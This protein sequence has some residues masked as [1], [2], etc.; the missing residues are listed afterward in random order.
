MPF[1][2]RIEAA[3]LLAEKLAAYR[4]ERPLVLAVPR[5]GVP[6]GRVVADALDGDLDVLFV[7]K[8][9]HP[10]NPEAAIGSVDEAGRI[11]LDQDAMAS[12]VSEAYVARAIA[13][14]ARA[15][16]QRRALYGRPPV[17][18]F[19][20]TVIIIDDG[21][22]TGATMAAALRAA[23]SRHPKELVAAVPVA[24]P[25][26]IDRLEEEADGVIILEAPPDFLAVGQFYDDFR[27]VPDVEVL[28]LLASAQP[29][30]A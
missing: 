11:E 8:I 18:P 29:A 4:G 15:I 3:E 9:G 22:A 19:G 25:D 2:D 10:G 14:A 24:S 1:R 30:A 5:G 12:G 27:Q 28:A 21:A 17:D 16:R 13:D 26:A 23:K 7:S 20:R 6:M